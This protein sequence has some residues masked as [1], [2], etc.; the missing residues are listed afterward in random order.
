MEKAVPRLSLQREKHVDMQIGVSFLCGTRVEN[1]KNLHNH[2]FYELFILVEGEAIHRINGERIKFEKGALCFVRKED[3]HDFFMV[4]NRPFKFFNMT[5]SEKNLTE[6]FSFLGSGFPSEAL[7]SEK[8]APMV[9]LSPKDLKWFINK[10]DAA[11]SLPADDASKRGTMLKILIFNAFTRFFSDYDEKNADMPEWLKELMENMRT[12]G[13]YI[14]GTER[15]FALSNKTREHVSRSMK[16]YTGMTVSEYVNS[17]RL[18]Y[19]ANMLRKSN[20][21]IT[22]IIFDSGFGNVSWAS[23]QFKKVFGVTMHEY[24]KENFEGPDGSF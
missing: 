12:Q 20:H 24:R 16:K 13:N 14:D 8:T 23:N 3:V 2:D 19:I 6:I 17:L 5:F 1:P 22:D 18:N 11:I 9:T 15:L 7:L 21:S 4:N 10:L